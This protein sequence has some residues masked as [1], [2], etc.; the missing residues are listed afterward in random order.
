[1]K[2]I[3]DKSLEPYFIEVDEHN[4]MVCDGK[5][6]LSGKSEGDIRKRRLSFHSSL[7]Q[8]V[9][10]ICMLKSISLDGDCNLSEFISRFEAVKSEI[11]D[12]ISI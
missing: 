5:I 2:Y 7:S 6:A 4:F 8:A 9:T 11:L 12:T 1:M 3:R 10:R